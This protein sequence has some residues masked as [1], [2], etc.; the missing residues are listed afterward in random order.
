[1][2]K[3]NEIPA[4]LYE[5]EE[6][7]VQYLNNIFE[8]QEKSRVINAI[9]NKVRSSLL[10]DRVLKN[11][12]FEINSLIDIEG[13]GIFLYNEETDSL[14]VGF[15]GYKGCQIDS[16]G[17]N[18]ILR[19]VADSL[20]SGEQFV[21][22][23]VEKFFSD[24]S[25]VEKINS[26]IDIKT[27]VITPMVYQ[28]KFI[29]LIAVYGAKPIINSQ[30]DL[31]Q[32]ISDKTSIAVFQ[33]Q[34]FSELKNKND[35][36]Q[37][38]Y[39]QA[40]KRDEMKNEFLVNISHELRTPL[41]SIIGFSKILASKDNE[42]FTPKQIQYVNNILVS[43][44]FLV[45]LINEFLDLS[46][47]EAG[48]LDL[49]YEW[50]NSKSVIYEVMSVLY[51]TAKEKDLN[52]EFDL[53][54]IYVNADKKRFTEV[55]Y[56]L[57]SNSIKFSN[58]NGVIIL[59]NKDLGNSVYVEVADNGIGISEEQKGN[60]FNKFV[61]YAGAREGTG[62]GLPLSKKIIEMHRGNIYFES[63]PNEL[64][65]FWFV[66]PKDYTCKEKSE[67]QIEKVGEKTNI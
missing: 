11:I 34:L 57:I 42:N 16:V 28:G 1:M 56:N 22:D 38:L 64:T 36:D 51:E 59:S 6:E 15:K 12:F 65:R 52:I 50:F 5:I 60:I 43:G 4:P 10:L 46:K 17:F 33:A 8:Q 9:S 35:K 37:N 67:Q 44:E 58:N 25:L 41:N 24:K 3:L 20:K 40:Q 21:D 26:N 27:F 2:K 62:L 19:H 53:K 23:T 49:T 39:R 47:I 66:I 48:V 31:L 29:G 45:K 30:L 32:N 55:M 61:S 7:I 63:V 13:I 54:N 14:N 18:Q